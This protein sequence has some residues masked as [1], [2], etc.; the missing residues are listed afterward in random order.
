V[1]PYQGHVL[2]CGRI[3]KGKGVC[4]TAWA[5]GATVN[6]P[7]VM[8]IENYVACDDTTQSEMVV[9]VIESSGLVS[10][11]LDLD[12]DIPAAFDEIDQVCLEAIV[13]EFVREEGV[14]SELGKALESLEWAASKGLLLDHTTAHHE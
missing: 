10:S 8:A 2:A 1:G 3:A 12:S 5:R 14:R 7:N 4:G 11:V 6:I 13:A 9:P